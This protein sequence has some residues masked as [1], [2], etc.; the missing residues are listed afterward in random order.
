MQKNTKHIASTE[1]NYKKQSFKGRDIENNTPT[2]NKNGKEINKTFHAIM[3]PTSIG[4]I[5]FILGLIILFII[6]FFSFYHINKQAFY[7]FFGFMSE[8]AFIII[9][10][11]GILEMILLIISKKKKPYLTLC[12]DKIIFHK[13]R[14]K[15]EEI[16]L[17][18]IED[19]V[20][21]NKFNIKLKLRN[22]KNKAIELPRIDIEERGKIILYFK[23]FSSTRQ[24]KEFS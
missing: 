2:H 10:L 22:G 7:D 20:K 4:N 5:F 21:I 9:I 11:G 24:L 17:D 6:A 15:K 8:Y 19:I 18:E 1:R 14:N 12:P 3:L 23:N 13:F 16:L